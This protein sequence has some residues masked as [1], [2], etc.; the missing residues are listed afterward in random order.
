MH[1]HSSTFCM[2]YIYVSACFVRQER[3]EDAS[4][5]TQSSP[6]MSSRA[7]HTSTQNLGWNA[8]LRL[9]SVQDY[10]CSGFAAQEVANSKTGVSLN[11]YRTQRLQTDSPKSASNHKPG[12]VPLDYLYAP[13]F[14]FTDWMILMQVLTGAGFWWMTPSYSTPVIQFTYQQKCILFSQHPVPRC[15]QFQNKKES[16]LIL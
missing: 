6:L 2:L 14:R 7:T 13:G 15:L 8:W 16:A 4:I 9:H 3:L 10:K 12:W 11:C 1:S 5:A